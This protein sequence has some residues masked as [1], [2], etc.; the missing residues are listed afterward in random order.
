M[1][2]PGTPPV[3]KVP[4]QLTLIPPGRPPAGT[5]TAT[6]V[7]KI[8]SSA[9]IGTIVNH[10]FVIVSNVVEPQGADGENVI[11]ALG[12]ELV[13]AVPLPAFT[14][15]ELLKVITAPVLGIPLAVKFALNQIHCPESREVPL[16]FDAL[17]DIAAQTGGGVS[18]QVRLVGETSMGIVFHP[19]REAVP[20][21]LKLPFKV[22]NEPHTAVSK[23]LVT[24]VKGRK[25]VIGEPPEDE[26]LLIA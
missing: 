24:A 23:V 7:R 13:I 8:S 3:S 25:P 6:P 4:V 9:L 16:K 10:V 1:E 22:G 20:E 12:A 19:A 17:P 5:G 14:I 15:L 2:I 11:L 18:P 26:L 21:K